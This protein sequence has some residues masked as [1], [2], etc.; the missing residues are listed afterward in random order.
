MVI[1]SADT[2]ERYAEEAWSSPEE[3]AAELIVKNKR[4][5]R[6]KG[7]GGRQGVLSN[8]NIMWRRETLIMCISL[9]RRGGVG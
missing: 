4:V 7:S 6:G 2:T 5:T 1:G 8:R 9:S 3:T